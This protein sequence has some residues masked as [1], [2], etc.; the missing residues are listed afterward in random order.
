V[1]NEQWEIILIH[2]ILCSPFEA[3]AHEF[4]DELRSSACKLPSSNPMPP[5]FDFTD[6]ELGGMDSLLTEKVFTHE[7]LCE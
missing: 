5:L 3:L 7:K 2:P 4:F 6:A 1:P